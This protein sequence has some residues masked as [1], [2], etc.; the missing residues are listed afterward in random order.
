MPDT[1]PCNAAART[2]VERVP[3]EHYHRRRLRSQRRTATSSRAEK[4]RQERSSSRTALWN[5]LDDCGDTRLT[6]ERRP[7]SVHRESQASHTLYPPQQAA[8]HLPAMA[9]IHSGGLTRLGISRERPLTFPIFARISV[10]FRVS[11]RN[12]DR[13]CK[14]APSVTAGASAVQRKRRADESTGKPKIERGSNNRALAAGIQQTDRAA[15]Q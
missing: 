10:T 15:R 14:G 6:S 9:P 7:V 13:S 8:H 3:A 12:H 1:T 4:D 5:K 2:R 11:E